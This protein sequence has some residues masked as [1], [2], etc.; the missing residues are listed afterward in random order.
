MA[1]LAELAAAREGEE[2]KDR[3]LTDD[4]VSWRR[5]CRLG[6][7]LRFCRRS[8]TWRWDLAAPA[9]L[10]PAAAGKHACHRR[11][12]MHAGAM[13][14]WHSSSCSLPAAPPTSLRS[15]SPPSLATC[16]WRTCAAAPWCGSPQLA[17][18]AAA[19]CSRLLEG[20]LW[21]SMAHSISMQH[22]PGK[23]ALRRPPV[24]FSM[25]PHVL[26]CSDGIPVV[27]CTPAG[28]H[29]LALRDLHPQVLAGDQPEGPHRAGVQGAAARFIHSGSRL[30]LRDGCLR[31]IALH[32]CQVARLSAGVAGNQLLRSVAGAGDT[33]AAYIWM[34]G[35]GR[36]CIL[37]TAPPSIYPLHPH[38]LPP[39]CATC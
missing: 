22:C 23:R 29:L 8:G 5:T 1:E 32:S 6:S 21:R 12:D 27:S 9:G 33:A 28:A 30:R 14:A 11:L 39:R 15:C 36:A 4:D 16:A 26:P 10:A 20:L 25:P 24:A 2:A 31:C 7:R 34:L 3:V 19:C 37:K 18:V 38:C 17:G 35:L 13:C